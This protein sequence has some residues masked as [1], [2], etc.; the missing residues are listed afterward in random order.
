MT[1]KVSTT[2]T[3]D[4]HNQAQQLTVAQSLQ[5]LSSTPVG[6]MAHKCEAANTDTKPSSNSHSRQRTT[7]G[8][9]HKQYGVNPDTRGVT[10]GDGGG[11]RRAKSGLSL[12]GGV[13]SH[14]AAMQLCIASLA[15]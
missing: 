5:R 12:W 3:L 13:R 15:D 14:H 6:A 4:Q 2:S 8:D 7:Q 9:K 10:G 1:N 11:V